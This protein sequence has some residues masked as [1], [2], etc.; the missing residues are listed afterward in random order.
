MHYISLLNSNTNHS[1]FFFL[2]LCRER[3]GGLS[4]LI[5]LSKL[6]FIR[7]NI[8]EL[9]ISVTA[10]IFFYKSLVPAMARANM[11]TVLKTSNN[12]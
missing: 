2:C 6:C 4:K 10:G 5:F 8:R 7:E 3:G 9:T 12:N 1:L 11:L